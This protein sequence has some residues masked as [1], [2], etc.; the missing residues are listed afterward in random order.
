MAVLF[1]LPGISV[2][3]HNAQGQLP[4]YA[5]SKPD[6][7]E[8]LESHP[9]VVVSNY[10]E[11]P[12]DGGRFWLKFCVE[13]P[14]MH[15]PHRTIFAFEDP[16]GGRIEASCDRRGLVNGESW[17]LLFGGYYDEVETVPLYRSLQFTKLNILPG[18]G[19]SNGISETGRKRMERIGT[20]QVRVLLGK[21]D[22]P[23]VSETLENRGE[24]TNFEHIAPTANIAT[25]EV[26]ERKSL[27]LGMTYNNEVVDDSEAPGFADSHMF[28]NGWD[29]PIAIFQFKYRSR[30]D[31]QKL[32][33]I[34][35]SP[36]LEQLLR[37]DLLPTLPTPPMLS[38]APYLTPAPRAFEN[39]TFAEVRG[40]ARKQYISFDKLSGDE[41][42]TLA[43]QKHAEQRLYANNGYAR[44]LFEVL[45]FA[46]VRS[47]AE[48]QYKS[49]DELNGDEIEGLARQGHFEAVA[50]P[51]AAIPGA[52]SE[53][54]GQGKRKVSIKLEDADEDVVVASATKKRK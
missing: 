47:L 34:E 4:E 24:T 9:S 54:N 15:S 40:L 52:S 5:D 6:I 16:V 29:N 7:V 18:D 39:L 26:A 19:E 20:L 48:K 53:R 25:E 35:K 32:L 14:Y 41:M 17:E 3:V 28:T 46:R 12:P 31:L 43:R 51:Q 13:A 2:T 11:A 23:L 49:F 42:E 44:L 33:L 45:T 21:W 30:A 38:S 36:E 37:E 50:S 1:Y 8:N 27:S 22:K 10:I